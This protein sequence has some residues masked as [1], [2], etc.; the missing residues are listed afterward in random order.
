MRFDTL[1]SKRALERALCLPLVGRLYGR[2]EHAKRSFGTERC[3]L[4]VQ[5]DL[6][7]HLVSK[8]VSRFVSQL[9][10]QIVT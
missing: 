9:V 5:Y 7:G 1:V 3:R 8:V 4:S 6:Q 2:E 10:S